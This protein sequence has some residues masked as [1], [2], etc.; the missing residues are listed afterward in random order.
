[1]NTYILNDGLF[2]RSYF[3]RIL[4]DPSLRI[5]HKLPEDGP[6]R[7]QRLVDLWNHERD[8]FMAVDSGQLFPMPYEGL[9]KGFRPIKNSESDVENSF[10]RPIVETILGY[11]VVQNRF[12]RLSPGLADEVKTPNQKPDMVLFADRAVHDHAVREADERNVVPDGVRFCQGAQVILDAKRFNK[13]VGADDPDGENGRRT[14]KGRSEPTA[15]EDLKQVELYLRGYQK[16]WGIL[17]NGRV[18]RLMRQGKIQKHV[19]FNLVLFLEDVRKTGITSE[20]LD[21]F[22]LFLNFFGVPAVALQVLDRMESES[23]ADTRK[24]RD[25]LREQ[26]HK[27]VEAIA[28]G[29]WRFSQ[30][31]YTPTPSQAEL[32]HLRELS[33]TFLYRLLFILKAEAQNLLPMETDLGAETPYAKQLSTRAIFEQLLRID[34]ATRPRI[35]SGFLLLYQLFD[36]IDRGDEGTGIPAYNGGLFNPELH[37][38]LNRLKLDDESL[39]RILRGLIYQRDDLRSSVPYADLDVRDLGDIYEGLLEQRLTLDVDADCHSYL[40]LTNQKGERKA[41]GSYFTPDSLV[42]HLVQKTVTPLLEACE[43]DPVRIL[44]LKVLDPA[45]GS[46]HFLVKAV[47]VLAAYLT[48]HCD[49]VDE[50][51]PDDN[52]PGE[53]AYWKRKVAENCIYGVDYNP[54]SVE[55]AKVALWLYT[56]QKG[57]PLSFLDHHLKC[58]NSLIGVSLEDLSAPGL[59]LRETKKGGFWEDLETAAMRKKGI[60]AQIPLPFP[61]NRAFFRDIREYIGRILAEPSESPDDIKAK[62]RAYADAVGRRL[63][64]HRLLADLWCAQWFLVE[65]DKLASNAF[66]DLYSKVKGVSGIAEDDRRAAE[67]EK[68]L[69]DPLVQAVN[70]ARED[71]YG[72]RPTRFFHWQLE[73]PEVAFDEN[74]EPRGGFGFDAVVGNPPWD[75]IKPA[76][77]DFYGPFSEEVANTQGASLD[78]LIMRLEAKKP[79]LVEGWA[80]YEDTLKRIVAF[81]SKSGFYKHQT[82]LVGG[83]KTGGDP[84]LFRYF[85]ERAAQ[86]AGAGGT[87]GFLVPCTLWQAEGCTGLRRYLFD[88]CA[89]QSLFTFENYRKWAFDID[90]RFKF[91]AII[92]MKK[93][94]AADH[95]FP[96]AFMLREPVALFGGQPERVLALSRAFMNRTS[97]ETLALLDVK[98]DG[99][100]A[101]VEKLHGQVYLKP[102]GDETN[103]WGV[104]YARELDMTNDSW[105]F[106]KREWMERRG[107]TQV[108]PVRQAD[109]TWTQEIKG[110]GKVAGVPKDLPD[111]GEYWVAA[112]E[113]YYRDR[114]YESREGQVNGGTAIWFI[115][116][117]DLTVVNAKGSRFAEE[118]FRVFPDAIYTALYEGRMVR[119]LD[120]AQ[121]KYLRG[122]GPKALWERLSIPEKY[123]SPRVFVNVAES[124]T[125]SPFRVGVCD[126]ARATDERTCLAAILSPLSLSGNTVPTLSLPTPKDNLLLAALLASFSTDFVI[127]LR[128]NTHLNWTQLSA[129]QLPH[130]SVIPDKETLNL[131]NLIIR[132]SCTTPELAA[133]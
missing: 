106:R 21:T 92:F 17:T 81:L 67:L 102:L 38:E 15:I 37:V 104:K 90:S 124:G 108:L 19:Q 122:E 6:E 128:I 43:D 68:L 116:P 97:P 103:G 66:S 111:G 46:G 99:E 115:H 105:R 14:K 40:K 118:H 93:T 95:A 64:A 20:A 23:E 80:R 112:C 73:F 91:T 125:P 1:M 49:P 30:N 57:K 11:S 55:L 10:I 60:A 85:V 56:A 84:D 45:M 117:E 74:G 35:T 24:V 52:G 12:L 36:A 32:D 76:K 121:K 51:V 110:P 109:G 59:L 101:L 126:V 7:L 100:L 77:R 34:P 70:R 71:G 13:G 18:W 28:D 75:K 42:E 96:A 113:K 69:S 98:S 87:V 39:F 2:S 72:P 44:N 78:A 9:P 88:D 26:A 79:E 50:G 8:Q 114:G 4:S 3:D 54:M 61:I 127:R 48:T 58:G 65:P 131:R 129:L 82:T 83:K 31:K 130:P 47:D 63:G 89:V 33:L 86:C 119:N 27:A 29:Y 133:Y 22:R 25:I 132:L 120:D 62:S 107:F 123:Y 5:L 41:S 94:P 53:L 16:K